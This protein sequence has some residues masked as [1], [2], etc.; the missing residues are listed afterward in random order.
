MAQPAYTQL[1]QASAARIQGSLFL[2]VTAAS[3]I[4]R[5][6]DNFIQSVLVFG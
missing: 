6:P 5:F 1:V 4:P 3:A 2:S